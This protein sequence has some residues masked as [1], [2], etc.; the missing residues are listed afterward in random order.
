LAGHATVLGQL[1]LEQA[2]HVTAF[3]RHAPVAEN[4]TAWLAKNG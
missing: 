4:G 3:G 1:N 2:G